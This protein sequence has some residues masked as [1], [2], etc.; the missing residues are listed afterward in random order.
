MWDGSGWIPAPPQS[1]VLPQQSINQQE[2]TSVANQ[3]GV[4]PNQLT[5]AAPYFDQNQ[6]GV[7]QQ[8]ELQQAA[9]AI[10][11]SPTAPV[12]VQAPQ[13]LIQMPQKSMGG[14]FAVIGS[15][16]VI[17]ILVLLIVNRTLLTEN[18]S[19]E[20]SDWDGDGISDA[21]DPDDDNDG[22]LDE[23]DWYDEGNGGLIITFTK[24]QIWS[25]GYYDSDGN[26]DVY[27]YVGIGDGDCQGM[28]YFEYL[29][30]INEDA[31]TLNNWEEYITDIDD[32]QSRACVSVTIYDED[33]WAVD[34]I[35]DFVPGNANYYNHP[36]VLSAGE[37]DILI[38]ED[39]RGEN[40]LSI[41]VEYE[42]SRSAVVMT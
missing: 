34:D 32:D 6:D 12:P 3:T 2:V 37:G 41:L 9:M 18:L 15:L 4:D 33:P 28:Q 17:S 20:F 8:S 40:E 42:I 5:Q 36:F 27:A 26:P 39:N 21:N 7:L 38:S 16:V 1:N 10:S 14:V 24:F 19:E 22:Y 23:N 35:L 13:M 30:D 31:S 25:E 11:Q 29:D